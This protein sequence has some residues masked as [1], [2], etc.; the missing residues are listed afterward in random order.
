MEATT[1]RRSTDEPARPALEAGTAVA[2]TVRTT[3]GP[4][5]MDTMVVDRDGSVLVTNTGSSVLERLDVAHPIGR[6]AVA[7]AASQDRAASDG[8]TRTVILLGALLDR[9]RELIEDGAHPRTVVKGY[10]RATERA[11]ERLAEYAAPFDDDERERLERIVA[12]TVNGRWDDDA[13][14]HF[15]TAVVSALR[16]VD[17]DASRLTL[18]GYAGEG[19][20]ASTLVDGILV[21][22]DASS[23]SVAPVVGADV[24]SLAAPRIALVRDAIGLDDTAAGTTVTVDDAHTLERVRDHER[25]V[26]A[27]LVD[28]VRESGADA[29]F[30][31]KPVDDGVRVA[32]AR[33]GVLVVE[34]TRSDEFAAIERATD[35]DAVPS[36]RDLDAAALGR[37][38]SIRRREIGDVSTLVVADCPVEAH[39]SLVLRGGTP[40]VVEET[41]RIVADGIDVLRQAVRDGRVVPGGGASA[42]A[43]S[44]TLASEATR[45]SGREQLVRSAYAEA[46]TTLPRTL[47]ENAGR[48]PTTAIADLKRRQRADGPDIGIG[49]DGSLVD[50]RAAEIVEPP[51]VLR[52]CLTN[53]FETAAT[54]LR[55]DDVLPAATANPSDEGM[56][57]DG[58]DHGGYPWA[59]GH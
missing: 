2:A 54:V 32:L 48:D 1:R 37:A 57:P 41:R 43:L 12:T 13:V 16:R 29:L 49:V 15:A 4:N 47:A 58:P 6:S 8:S 22:H 28:A 53:A 11:R 5:G 24:P 39:A 30:C 55:V 3:L 7:A 23:T 40:H 36:P 14:G 59:I 42:T 20:A 35:A 9:A 46:L 38:G 44:Q 31:A 56:A 18:H 27:G 10:A 52:S 26:T 50:A 25:D 45:V 17:F 51:T 19:V 33:A 21:D 34:R